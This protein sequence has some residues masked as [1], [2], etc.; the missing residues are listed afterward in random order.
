MAARAA[1]H[2]VKG[3]EP[4]PEPKKKL[5]VRDA[6]A[7][8]NRKALL[9][10]MQERIARAVEDT[11]TPPRDL[12]SLSRRLQDISR[13]L[14]SMADPEERDGDNGPAAT[15]DEYDPAAI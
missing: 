13:E 1:L 15:G 14:E 3:P 2:A 10:A 7:S 4:K 6:A 5:G 12:A 11:N 8:G 9:E